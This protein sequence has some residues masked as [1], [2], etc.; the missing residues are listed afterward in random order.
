LGARLIL[1]LSQPEVVAE[2]RR[3]A[4]GERAMVC[5]FIGT[6]F[7]Q[8]DAAVAK[9]SW[10]RGPVSQGQSRSSTP[11]RNG[12]FQCLLKPQKSAILSP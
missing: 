2:A 6:A 10:R 7:A 4:W 9:S 8:D 11:V 1:M 5:A 3:E 12:N